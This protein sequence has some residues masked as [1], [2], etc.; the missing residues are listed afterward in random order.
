MSNP[1]ICDLCKS[2]ITIKK[3]QKIRV[4]AFT[5]IPKEEFKQYPHD[6]SYSDKGSFDVCKKCFNKESKRLK[7]ATND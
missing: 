1:I 5:E 7:G 6:C 3:D 2:E 4:I